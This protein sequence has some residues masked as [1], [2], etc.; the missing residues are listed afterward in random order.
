MAQDKL[1]EKLL[2][3]Q[4]ALAGFGSFAFRA[5]DLRAVLNETASISAICMEAPFCKVCRFRPEHNDLLIEAGH[6]WQ[7]DIVGVAVS[8]A[9]RTSP[10]G[11]A[12]VTGQPVICG[13]LADC[14]DFALPTFYS[15]HNI[16][17]AINV[18]IQG[19]DD[20]VPYGILE[21]DSPVLR[22]YDEH[23]ISF[24][25]SLAN[26]LAEAVAI[27][28]RTE[29]LRVALADKDVLSRELQHRVR[30]NLHLIYAMLNMEAESQPEA[31]QS[32]RDIADR[33]Q[34]LAAVYDH[35]LGI[36]MARTMAF[37]PYL[38]KLCES[39]RDVHPGSV[40]LVNRPMASVMV[41]LDT[42]TAMGLAMT[43]LIANSYK[44][45][46]PG[47]KGTIEVGLHYRDGAAVLSVQDDG[48][49]IEPVQPTKRQ[50]LGLVQRLVEQVNAAINIDQ[51]GNGT[52][53]EIVLAKA[54]GA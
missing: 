51:T 21:I 38:R 37:D 33:V 20:D 52:R 1:V 54:K 23:D 9:D 39:L 47:G 34:A 18:I 19:S 45:A 8:K 17:S 2:S 11:L 46:F 43:E 10:G 32:F 30:N 53:C 48:V 36:G 7:P 29:S 14:D 26:V 25:T 28:K 3:H 16:V 44:H 35:L 27:T 49:G 15:L 12:F 50:G 31:E 24:L 6:G 42:A 40:R 5:A 13:N 22:T 41:D 4:K